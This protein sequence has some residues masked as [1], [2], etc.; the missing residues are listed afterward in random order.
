MTSSANKSTSSTG[1][2]L[3]FFHF[4]YFTVVKGTNTTEDETMVKDLVVK[5]RFFETVNKKI[6]LDVQAN[7]GAAS[8]IPKIEIFKRSQEISKTGRKKGSKTIG[9]SKLRQINPNI[10]FIEESVIGTPCDIGKNCALKNYEQ[11]MVK[12]NTGCFLRPISTYISQN[13]YYE[14]PNTPTNQ[15]KEPVLDRILPGF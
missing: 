2:N 10:K 7:S 14:F 8:N 15:K 3:Y 5:K 1:S 12:I 6:K 11:F 4:R 13:M 9:I